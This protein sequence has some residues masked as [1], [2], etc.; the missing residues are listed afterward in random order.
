MEDLI[1][2]LLPYGGA[3]TGGSAVLF[4]AWRLKNSEEEVE[5]LR[6]DVKRLNRSLNL[7][8]FYLSKKDTNFANF[9]EKH[10]KNTG[11]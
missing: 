1:S 5:R 8:Y 7:Y 3:A 4:I 9:L 10:E 11:G 6:A 2:Q